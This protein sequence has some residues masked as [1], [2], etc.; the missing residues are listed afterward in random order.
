[1]PERRWFQRCVNC[2]AWRLTG[3]YYELYDLSTSCEG[4]CKGDCC[5]GW[6]WGCAACAI[7]VAGGIID[8]LRFARYQVQIDLLNY[9]IQEFNADDGN[10]PR[11]S[12][13]HY[14]KRVASIRDNIICDLQQNGL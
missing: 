1:M 9:V 3:M 2:R 12:T 4:Q 6:G 13:D 5:H 7:E 8:R 14:I 11:T 10:A